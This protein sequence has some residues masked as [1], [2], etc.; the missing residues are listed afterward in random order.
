MKMEKVRQQVISFN[1]GVSANGIVF[2]SFGA[3]GLVTSP[4]AMGLGLL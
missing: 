4:F 1:C 3:A 2:L